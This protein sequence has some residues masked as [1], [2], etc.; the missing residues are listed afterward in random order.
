[1]RLFL[2]ACEY[3]EYAVVVTDKP[4]GKL[5]SVIAEKPPSSR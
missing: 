5:F 2:F 1:M 4:S 3:A